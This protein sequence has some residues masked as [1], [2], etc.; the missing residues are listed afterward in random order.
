V[1]VPTVSV[2]A[3]SQANASLLD[4]VDDDVFDHEVRPELLRA[5]LANEPN[6]LVVAV[7]QAEVDHFTRQMRTFRYL[8]PRAL[9]GPVMLLVGGVAR[10]GAADCDRRHHGGRSAQCGRTLHANGP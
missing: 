4:R 2:H 3:I 10:A 1:D 9:A 6:L 5:F 8:L 7:V